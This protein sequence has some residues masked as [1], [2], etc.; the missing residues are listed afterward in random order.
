MRISWPKIARQVHTLLQ[1]GGKAMVPFRPVPHGE[2]FAQT[3]T[4]AEGGG[5]HTVKLVRDWLWDNRKPLSEC[6]A[7][8]AIQE[9][10]GW[11]LLG[12]AAGVEGSDGQEAQ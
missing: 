2:L 5:V 12:V 8:V 10:E 4:S 6:Q 11:K 3:E 1:E 9:P 7:I